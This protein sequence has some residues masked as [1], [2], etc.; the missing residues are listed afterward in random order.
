[1][2]SKKHGT[3]TLQTLLSA[4]NKTSQADARFA[5]V[6]EGAGDYAI[7][8]FRSRADAKTV[9]RKLRTILPSCFAPSYRMRIMSKRQAVALE[10]AA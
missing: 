4:L 7:T 6:L 10:R 2:A 3:K 5:L 1:M 9:R 8:Y